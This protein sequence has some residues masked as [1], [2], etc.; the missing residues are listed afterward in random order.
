MNHLRRRLMKRSHRS[1][2]DSSSADRASLK[3]RSDEHH[4]WRWSLVLLAATLM[5]AIRVDATDKYKILH[6]FSGCSVAPSGALISD[7]SGNFYGTTA[8]GCPGG[9][10]FKFTRKGG[11]G[12]SYT[13][14]YEFKHP[15]INGESP[16]GQLIFDATGNLYGT[17]FGGGA[18]NLGTAFELSPAGKTWK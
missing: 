2:R 17:T 18:H 15:R 1:C 13:V 7:A 12:W 11:G 4:K 6:Y 9:A 8:G 10:V 5:L 14:L 16:A 3:P